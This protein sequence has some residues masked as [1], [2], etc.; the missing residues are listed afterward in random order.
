MLEASQADDR[1]S[2]VSRSDRPPTFAP[3]QHIVNNQ[4]YGP[5]SLTSLISKIHFSLQDYVKDNA[6]DA[7][8]DSETYVW[9]RSLQDCMSMMEDMTKSL[10]VE[11]RLDQS[12]DGRPLVL[13]PPGLLHSCIDHYFNQVNWMLPIFRQSTLSEHIRQSYEPG[14]DASEGRILCF[15]NILLHT[16]ETGALGSSSRAGDFG[17]AV[18]GNAVRNELRR[19]LYANFIRGLNQL[20]RLLTPSL[21]NV[22]ALLSTVRSLFALTQSSRAM[23]LCVLLY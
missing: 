17:G 9:D 11:S 4:Y 16:L 23:L 5:S 14:C 18:T 22:Q 3:N 2:D 15:N 13:P 12:S 7:L 1:C 10:G 21:V 20:D 8:N 19:S 6:D